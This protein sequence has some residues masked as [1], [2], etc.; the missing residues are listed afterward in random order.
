MIRTALTALILLLAAGRDA[1]AVIPDTGGALERPPIYFAGIEAIEKG[2][3]AQGL[4][5]MKGFVEEDPEDVDAWSLVGFTLRKLKRFVDSEHAYRTALDID[6][7][8]LAANAYAGTLYLETGRAQ[9]A[10]TRLQVLRQLCADGVGCEEA[11]KLAAMIES[12][13]ETGKAGDDW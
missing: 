1:G 2:D 10:E 13:R 3:Y 8:H 7:D 9:E 5:I 11:D 12:F 4:E 6:P